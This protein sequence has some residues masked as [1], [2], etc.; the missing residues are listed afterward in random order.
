MPADPIKDTQHF[1]C[2][3]SPKRTTAR[4]FFPRILSFLLQVVVWTSLVRVGEASHPGPIL[5]TLNPTGALYKASLFQELPRPALWGLCE[6]H[7]TKPG[8][9]KFRYGLQQTSPDTRFLPGAPAPHLAQG[10]ASIGGKQTGVGFLSQYPTRAL[11]HTWDADIWQS[12]RI[13]AC[14]SFVDGIWVEAGVAYGYASDT[15]TRST[16]DKTDQVLHQLTQR[17]VLQ[18]S[19]PRFICGD[20][21]HSKNA[22]PQFATWRQHGFVEIQEYAA[23][24]W[25]RPVSGTTPSGNVIDHIW[26]S[27][28]LLPM[29]ESVHV[30]CDWFADHHL[31]YGK[32][33]PF[34]ISPPVPVWRKPLPLPWDEVEFDAE[35]V[36]SSDQEPLIGIPE[37]FHQLEKRC[38]DFLV[39]QGKPG[40]IPQQQG[41]CL[42]RTP[43]LKK[44]QV[45]PLKP[46]RPSEVQVTFLGENFIHTKWCRQLRRLQSLVHAAKSIKLGPERTLHLQQLWKSIRN[47]PGF[48]KGFPHAWANRSVHLPGGPAELPKLAPSLTCCEAIFHSFKLE[49]ETLERALRTARVKHAKHRRELDRNVT[50]EDVA[51]PRS[52]PV[53]TLVQ[54]CQATVS[55]VTDDHLG[56]SY[57]PACLAGMNRVVAKLLQMNKGFVKGLV[58]M[59]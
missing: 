26:L 48:P 37:V 13:Q 52:L 25:G 5:G 51:R 34:Q 8:L 23:A 33:K 38:H 1:S 49:F 50:F 20:F 10:V 57:T 39:S 41:R 3:F 16:M 44:R 30:E 4:G 2:Q 14:A 31:V 12:A 9:A 56:F 17:I 27:S 22:L 54:T 18:S 53:Q 47:A 43:C 6:S 7:L 45:T 42:T 55:E 46:S 15:Y 11:T 28:E 40:L 35:S 29:L 59:L 24:K 19:G 21:N 36:P 58:S 32:F